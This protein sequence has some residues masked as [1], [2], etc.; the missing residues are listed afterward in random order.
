MARLYR[1][2]VEME[3]RDDDQTDPELMATILADVLNCKDG[4]AM[5]WQQAHDDM[6]PEYRPTFGVERWPID[7][8]P[9]RV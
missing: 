2:M 3:V 6:E 8:D 7:G 1:F 5:D 9:R 4:A